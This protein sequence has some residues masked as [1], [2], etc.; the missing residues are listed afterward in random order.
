MRI[1]L[2]VLIVASCIASAS[3]Q[4]RTVHSMESL[5]RRSFSELECIYRAAEPGNRPEGFHRGHVVLPPCDFLAGPRAKVSNFLWQGKHFCD[6]SLVNQFRGAKFI[7]AQVASGDSWL[8]GRPAHI[9]DY[10]QTSRLWAD[11]RDEA[12]EVSPGV[13]LG[14]MYLRRCPEPKLK[15]IFILERDCCR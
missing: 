13:Y 15:L 7:K 14:A 10:Q 5:S 3:A 4:E 12:R 6:D 2:S 9:L 11:V 1:G 8:D